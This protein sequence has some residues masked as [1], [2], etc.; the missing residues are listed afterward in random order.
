M[1]RLSK[2]DNTHENPTLTLE[3]DDYDV[4]EDTIFYVDAEK[5]RNLMQ[6]LCIF[7]N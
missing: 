1:T 7:I 6:K 3:V 5:V 2:S 4:E